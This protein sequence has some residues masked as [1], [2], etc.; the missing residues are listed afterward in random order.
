MLKNTEK[1]LVGFPENPFE[2]ILVEGKLFLV[3]LHVYEG[4]SGYAYEYIPSEKEY[5]FSECF[6]E[7]Y[8]DF[9]RY[10]EEEREISKTK[11]YEIDSDQ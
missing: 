7:N 2:S 6:F 4:G 1:I 8:L 9:K 10:C 3:L 5:Y 11:W